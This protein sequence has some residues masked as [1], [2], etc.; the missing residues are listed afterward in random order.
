MSVSFS[1]DTNP[2]NFKWFLHGQEGCFTHKGHAEQHFEGVVRLPKKLKPKNE[3]AIAKDIM[4]TVQ[5][6]AAACQVYF[7]RTGDFLSRQFV[8]A[9]KHTNDNLETINVDT[10][11]AD[12]LLQALDENE[13]VDYI[14]M[15]ADNGPDLFTETSIRGD[16]VVHRRHEVSLLCR[17]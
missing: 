8:H 1:T 6:S 15:F 17:A 12:R 9:L 2:A 16:G 14:A 4:T 5:N 7:K 3:L 10:S 11:P 13:D